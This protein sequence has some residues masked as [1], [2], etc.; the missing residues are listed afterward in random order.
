MGRGYI[1]RYQNLSSFFDFTLLGDDLNITP[2]RRSH[3]LL[4]PQ[5]ILWSDLPCSF[6]SLIIVRKNISS[7]EITVVLWKYFSQFFDSPPKFIFPAQRPAS[8]KMIKSLAINHRVVGFLNL[9]A[10][11]IEEDIPVFEIFCPVITIVLKGVHNAF[12]VRS[13]NPVPKF[14]FLD[15]L[16]SGI[17]LYFI[18]TIIYLAASWVFEENSWIPSLKL[19][20]QQ[21]CSTPL[22][23]FELCIVSL[24]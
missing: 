10:P 7:R 1:F 2:A 21:Q 8:S 12:V 16:Q 9:A 13:I 24:F 6:K 11:D 20:P 19:A 23:V 17:I 5:L 14:Q 3:R 15:L 22:L 4:D 18:S